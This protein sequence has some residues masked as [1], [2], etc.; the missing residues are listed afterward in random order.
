MELTPQGEHI[1]CF[2]L[3]LHRQSFCPQMAK[4]HVSFTGEYTF[5][6]T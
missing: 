1:G 5:N 2:L 6:Y 3:V 4:L